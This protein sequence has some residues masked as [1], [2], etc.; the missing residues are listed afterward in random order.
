MDEKNPIWLRRK[1]QHIVDEMNGIVSDAEKDERPLAE[2]EIASLNQ[3]R[4]EV[5]SLHEQID[6]IEA[7]PATDQE[8]HE[9]IKRADSAPAGGV[10]H[11]HKADGALNL[12]EFAMGCR[13]ISRGSNTDLRNRVYAA[14]TTYGS[15]GVGVDGGY[16]VPVDERTTIKQT[17]EAESHILPL[18]DQVS[19][20]SDTFS[21]PTDDTTPWGSSGQILAYWDS[22]GASYTAS[23]P[24]FGKRNVSIDKL[25]CLV[26]VTDELMMDA[27][28]ITSY[29]RR[30]VTEIMAYK[31]NRAICAGTGVGEPLGILNS[32]ALISTTKTG[33]QDADSFVGMNAVNAWQRLY[34]GDRGANVRWLANPNTMAEIMTAQ[35]TGQDV[36]AQPCRGRSA[37][38]NRWVGAQLGQ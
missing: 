18:V 37:D 11:G 3:M 1:K 32:S 21:A 19:T 24:N 22:E 10:T 12:G 4:A 15:E 5:I 31:I 7:I 17:V 35:I 6:L 34:D 29:L 26:P 23:K 30:K 20:T 8:I 9:T 38:P 2:E 25:T 33:S 36:T 28:T 27:P 13:D 16:L 14:A